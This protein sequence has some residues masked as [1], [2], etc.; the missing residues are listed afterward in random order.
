MSCQFNLGA[1]SAPELFCICHLA[2]ILIDRPQ[3]VADWPQASVAI[4]AAIRQTGFPRCGER[5][6]IK[7]RRT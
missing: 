6:T 2:A 1:G 3:A 7:N 4:D 5:V